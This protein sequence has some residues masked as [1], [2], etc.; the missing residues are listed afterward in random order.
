MVVVAMMPPAV[1]KRRHPTKPKDDHTDTKYSHF[2]L[3]RVFQSSIIWNRATPP[4]ATTYGRHF[5]QERPTTTMTNHDSQSDLHLQK[6]PSLIHPIFPSLLC[7]APA[8]LLLR[9]YL[10]AWAV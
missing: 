10:Q 8:S 7:P 2:S 9:F 3:I 6:T 4:N 1:E 5:A